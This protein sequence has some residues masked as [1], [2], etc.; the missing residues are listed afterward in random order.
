MIVSNG[1]MED[2]E[3][4]KVWVALLVI[5]LHGTGS[6]G[7]DVAKLH[8]E[9]AIR[10]ARAYL[11]E[12]DAKLSEDKKQILEQFIKYK[13]AFLDNN[14]R[15]QV[16]ALEKVYLLSRTEY[17][18]TKKSVI[19]DV[20]HGDPY[21]YLTVVPSIAYTS[22]QLTYEERL[23]IAER[24]SHYENSPKNYRVLVGIMEE[25]KPY[26]EIIAYCTRRIEAGDEYFR[27][28][29]AKVRIRQYGIQVRA[30]LLKKN[31]G[32]YEEPWEVLME[33]YDP[34]VLPHDPIDLVI[35][36][37]L[38]DPLNDHQTVE[39]YASLLMTAYGFVLDDTKIVPCLD[40]L[41][42]RVQKHEEWVN[43]KVK[44]NGPLDAL[45]RC[46]KLITRRG[47]KPEEWYGAIRFFLSRPKR[48]EVSQD[49]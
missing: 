48:P 43:S 30:A 38:A 16:D 31:E 40:T 10:E 49:S 42:S 46:R 1:N 13:Q 24:F 33:R 32:T 25:Q 19:W 37:I 6:Y 23:E 11:Q 44:I 7:D 36:E 20:F 47:P 15:S 9:R 3:M 14:D 41:I 35:D 29:R 4:S 17:E 5:M 26:P 39:E 2:I 45:T 27:Y 21:G 8:A 22:S 34:N 28:L 12:N 18:S